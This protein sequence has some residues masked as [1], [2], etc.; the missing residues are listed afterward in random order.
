MEIPYGCEGTH[1]NVC[2]AHLSVESQTPIK[3]GDLRTPN[4]VGI[5]SVMVGVQLQP[6]REYLPG[7]DVWPKGSPAGYASLTRDCP[8]RIAAP[9]TR[10]IK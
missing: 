3:S 9:S 6:F 5:V 7:W 8:K 2:M 10:H 4:R 1:Q